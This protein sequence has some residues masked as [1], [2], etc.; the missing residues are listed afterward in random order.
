[1]LFFGGKGNMNIWHSLKNLS[2]FERI[3]WLTS[4]IFVW[5]SFMLSNQNDWMTI[6]ASLIGVT[7]LIFV[8]KGDVVGQILTIVFSLIYGIISYRFKYYG[9]IIT[10]L[11][12]TA[13]IAFL[14][15]ITW[16]KHPYS[17]QEVKVSEL[18]KKQAIILTILTIVVTTFLGMVLKKLGTSNLELSIVSIATSF[19]ASSLMMLRSHYYAIAY[20]TND[21]VLI[22][23]WSLASLVDSMYLP[24][25]ICFIVF[26]VNDLYGFINWKK[27]KNDQ[28]GE[29][30]FVGEDM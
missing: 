15:V 21:L 20:A 18:T 9:E 22:I 7:A 25:V 13:P 1:M 29:A 4:V 10:Y 28:C 5:G 3:L 26:L 23:L 27:M 24:M 17:K 12:M 11:G 8:A 2:A 14:S 16:L 6:V 30:A 19:M